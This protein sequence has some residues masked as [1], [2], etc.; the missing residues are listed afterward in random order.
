ML[1]SKKSI[2]ILIPINI[3][4]WGFFIY[5]FYVAYNETE[6]PITH[7]MEVSVKLDDLKDSI[8]YK[9]DLAYDDPFLKEEPKGRIQKQ[10]GVTKQE[11]P[12]AKLEKESKRPKEETAKVIPDIKYLGLVKNSASGFATAIVTINGSSKLIKQDEIIDGLCFKNFTSENLTVLW[13]KEK[14][15][16]TK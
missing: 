4:I 13:N 16:I 10:G 8:N 5:R 12:I 15:V 9:L 3:L 7:E 14:I 2:Y 1:K 11:K 6:L